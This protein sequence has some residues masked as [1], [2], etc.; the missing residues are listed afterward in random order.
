MSRRTNYKNQEKGEDFESGVIRNESSTLE[1]PPE[2]SLPRRHNQDLPSSDSSVQNLEQDNEEVGRTGRR[3]SSNLSG[4]GLLRTR[5][6]VGRVR[7]TRI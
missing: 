1:P 2:D 4:K 5:N 6:R 3:P 7:A